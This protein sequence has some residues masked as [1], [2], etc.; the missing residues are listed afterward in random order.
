MQIKTGTNCLRGREKLKDRKRIKG[1]RYGGE[2][3]NEQFKKEKRVSG[4][5]AWEEDCKEASEFGVQV[6]TDDGH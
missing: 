3:K 6:V 1:E 5:M 4:V 2:T